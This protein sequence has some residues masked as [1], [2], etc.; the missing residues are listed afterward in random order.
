MAGPARFTAL[1]LVWPQWQGAVPRAH[2]LLPTAGV[3]PLEKAARVRQRC[4]PDCC[5]GRGIR[6]EADWQIL[7]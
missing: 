7:T 3:V 1:T 6:P 5:S 4:G 2:L